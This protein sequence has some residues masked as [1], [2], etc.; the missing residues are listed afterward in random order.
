MAKELKVYEIRITLNG[1]KPPIWRKVAVSSDITLGELHEVIQIAMGWTNSH[2]HQFILQSKN[3]KPVQQKQPNSTV[4]VEKKVIELPDGRK[5]YVISTKPCDDSVTP[6]PVESALPW[7]NTSARNFVTKTTPWGDPT[8]MEGEDEKTVTLGEV[9]PKVKSKL[10]YEY[11]FGDDWEHTI[12]VQKIVT[13]EP[14]G[15]YPICLSGKK[16]CP[17]EDC[18]GIWGYY[19]MLDAVG[20][21]KHDSH[22]EMIEWIGDHFDSDAFDL[23]EVNAILAKWRKG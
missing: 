13:P 14:A 21:P 18:G 1:S 23:E 11:D 19:E 16:A 12:E 5:G 15:K 8:E 10:I 4:T 9:C 20:N 7:F 2:M 22:K 17:P 6:K 3:P